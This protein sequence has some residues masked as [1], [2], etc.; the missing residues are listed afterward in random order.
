M[1]TTTRRGLEL[2][3]VLKPAMDAKLKEARKMTTTPK[4]VKRSAASPTETIADDASVTSDNDTEEEEQVYDKDAPLTIGVLQ[5]LLERSERRIVKNLELG[6]G[7]K[8]KALEGRMVAK[9]LDQD[10]YISQLG[11]NVKELRDKDWELNRRMDDLENRSRRNNIKI[12]GLEELKGEG[13][14]EDGVSRVVD[15]C[16]KELELEDIWVNRAH[17]LPADWKTGKKDFIAHIPRD[18]D[19]QA[20]FRNAAKLKGKQIFISRDL[21]GYHLSNHRYL[22][23]FRKS[24]FDRN[25]KIKLG[26]D[27]FYYGERRYY[28]DWNNNLVMRG[29][30]GEVD[31]SE[32]LSN[33]VRFPVN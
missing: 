33:V 22:T 10:N 25:I 14:R 11:G 2:G 23:K 26:A 30:G 12:S 3:E 8:L 9:N 31:A 32:F 28:I 5:S 24:M 16:V 27:C 21:V 7:K 4:R 18:S 20:I 15:F 13:G 17:R 6:F 19:Y 1:S 29:E